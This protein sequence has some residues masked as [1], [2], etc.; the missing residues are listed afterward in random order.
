MHAVFLMADAYIFLRQEK[1][2]DRAYLGTEPAAGAAGVVYLYHGVFQSKVLEKKL[3][4]HR[5]K[6]GKG[7]G[8][9]RACRWKM[10][11]MPNGR[12]VFLRC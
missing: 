8:A 11:H 10:L 3:L 5:K 12:T 7:K 4:Q 2:G 6:K 1:T 9:A